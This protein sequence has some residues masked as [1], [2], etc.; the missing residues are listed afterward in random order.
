MWICLD[1]K[2]KE[3]KMRTISL[4]CCKC[5]NGKYLVIDCISIG[6]D[7]NY[8]AFKANILLSSTRDRVDCKPFGTILLARNSETME[9]MIKEYAMLYTV[10]KQMLVQIPE[11]GDNKQ[12]FSAPGN[13][14]SYDREQDKIHQV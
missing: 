10:K 2:D 8:R 3:Y 7:E 11:T 9:K 5:R 4:E 12:Y 1:G 13:N 6:W 14:W